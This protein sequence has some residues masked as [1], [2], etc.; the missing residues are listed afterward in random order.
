MTAA[1][2]FATA[3]RWYRACLH[4]HTTNSD[5]LMPPEALVRHYRSA[6]FDALAI[7][8][9][10]HVTDLAAHSTADF[11]VLPG[12]EYNPRGPG[13]GR[14]RF[15]HVVGIGVQTAV[16]DA[17]AP[18]A[19]VEAIHAQGGVAIV[20]HPSWTG[21]EGS[22]VA[23]A[24][25]ADAVE[26]WNAGCEIEVARGDS[27][28]QWDWTLAHGAALGGLA[29]DDSHY[30]G[31]DSAFAWVA[32]RLPEL[33]RD[34]VIAALR[35]RCYY[36]STGPALHAVAVEGDVVR[37]TC[38][39]ARAIHVLGPPIVGSGLRAGRMGN[40]HQ[41]ERLRAEDSWAE[42]ALDGD[43]LTG[44]VFHLPPYAPWLRVVVEDR[45]GHRAWSNPLWRT[46][47]GWAAEPG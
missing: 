29:A 46:R 44:G 22:E 39:P 27:S 41:A 21:L 28:P 36:A 11:L 23:S 25:G 30:P 13:V 1:N 42:G 33:T 32:L 17:N 15:F 43:G 40:A 34:H 20:A 45:A 37:V 6:G 47:A 10:W 16:A 35:N 12:I 31:F 26:V 8:D 19:F 3:G 9:H 7:T 38:S 24:T 14:L 5:G 2:P 18:P 4:A